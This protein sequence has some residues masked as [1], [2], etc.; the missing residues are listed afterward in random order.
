M[1]ALSRT[2]TLVSSSSSTCG[3][4][5]GLSRK[6]WSWATTPG[7]YSYMRVPASMPLCTSASDREGSK[8][9]YS[10]TGLGVP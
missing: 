4:N 1:P 9:K 3:A 2:T 6:E 10:S 5:G 7:T 8:P